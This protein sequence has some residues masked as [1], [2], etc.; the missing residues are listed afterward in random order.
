M[1]QC[2]SCSDRVSQFLIKDVI[3]K[4]DY[5]E[6]DTLFRIFL[7]RLL[8]KS[9]TWS[10][11]E[12]KLGE[13]SLK[14]F[15]FERYS[16]ALEEIRI[17]APIYGNAFILCATKA[18]GY[19]QK[20]KNHLALLESVFKKTKGKI[21]L[22]K[23]KSLKQLFE[24]LRELPL[25]GDFMAYQIAIDMNYSEVFNFNENDFTSA[26]PGAIRGIKKCVLD[27]KGKTNEYIIHYMVENQ[28]KEF[29]RLGIQFKNLWGRPMHAIDCQGWFCE[30]DKYS[31]VKFPELVSNRKKFKSTFRPSSI[32]IEYF[33]PPKWRVNGKTQIEIN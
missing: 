28:E 24:N 14:N 32:K 25:I 17:D 2:V 15:T 10:S 5:S 12:S 9:E 33:Y 30:T 7:F 8:N 31:R 1:L 26:G 20:H 21:Q 19:D 11:L 16:K 29:K 18:F 23:S 4:E 13:I 22:T 3:Y 27:T 6:E